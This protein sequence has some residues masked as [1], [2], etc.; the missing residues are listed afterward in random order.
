MDPCGRCD[1]C[2]GQL[3]RRD[4]S[5]EVSLLLA[6]LAEKA[7]RGCDLRLLSDR[8]AR[9]HGRDAERWG[10]LVRRLVQ[11]ELLQESDD[12]GQRLWMRA[13]GQRYLSDPWPLRWAG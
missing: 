7:E 3:R 13:S 8:M 4:W 10:W 1:V 6:A 11:E 9:E 12:G 5:E 2:Q